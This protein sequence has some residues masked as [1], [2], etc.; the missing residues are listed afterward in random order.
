MDEEGIELVERDAR[1]PAFAK[2]VGL[3]I[4]V[5]CRFGKAAKEPH[6]G[7]VDFSVPRIDSRIYKAGESTIVRHH[8]ARP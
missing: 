1:G 8:V 6:H 2:R 5:K 7:E 3:V 4:G